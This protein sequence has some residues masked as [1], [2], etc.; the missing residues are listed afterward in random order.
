M[1]VVQRRLFSWHTALSRAIE[2]SRSVRGGNYVQLATVDLKGTPRCRTVVQRG[3]ID[4]HEKNRQMFKFI[5]D[6]RSDKVDQIKH[7]PLGEMV[8]WFL[9]TEEQFRISGH[10]I[11]VDELETNVKLKNA[12]IQTWEELRDTAREQFYLPSPGVPLN[13]SLPDTSSSNS[14]SGSSSSSSSSSDTV[15]S[16]SMVT[17]PCTFLLLLL[18]AKKVDYLNLKDNTRYIFTKNETNEKEEWSAA[19]EF[20]RSIRGEEVCLTNSRL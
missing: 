16:I 15:E 7:R 17:P 18:D 9:K 3:F 13:E 19:D 10:I 12:R 8:W 14:S 20:G 11:L 4:H 1:A 2:T 5:T 6:S